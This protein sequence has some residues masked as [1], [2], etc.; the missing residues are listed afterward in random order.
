MSVPTISP[1]EARR[2]IAEG[3]VLIDVRRGQRFLRYGA[4]ACRD[5]VE[6]RAKDHLTRALVSTETFDARPWLG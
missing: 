3:G 5:A 6:P 1:A 2:L 4:F